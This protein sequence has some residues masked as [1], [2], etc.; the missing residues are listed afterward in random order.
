MKLTAPQMTEM[1]MACGGGWRWQLAAGH[2]IYLGQ[3]Q[4]PRG[5]ILVEEH[6]G[7]AW[8]EIGAFARLLATFLLPSVSANNN[9]QL[10]SAP[11]PQPHA[12]QSKIYV[13][14]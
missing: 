6:G 1:A 2:T 11:S 14:F 12:V 3:Q 7:G 8:E 5:T 4:L 13:H 9:R 10:P